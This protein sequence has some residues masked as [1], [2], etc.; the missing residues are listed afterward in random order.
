M[1]YMYFIGPY[2]VLFFFLLLAL[3]GSINLKIFYEVLT[4]FLSHTSNVCPPGISI[5][6]EF[7]Y[8]T[9][10]KGTM[11]EKGGT[12]ERLTQTVWISAISQSYLRRWDG[13]R[14][15]LVSVLIQP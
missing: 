6:V 2:R 10:S 12:Q 13:A 4:S 11:A 14:G 3:F 5:W 7:S 8:F 15:F 9:V 1:F